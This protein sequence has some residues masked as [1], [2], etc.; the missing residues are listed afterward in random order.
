MADIIDEEI[1]LHLVDTS[2]LVA[3]A[4]KLKEAARIKKE[5]N[6]IQQQLTFSKPSPFIQAGESGLLP[7]KEARAQDMR[8]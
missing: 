6:K 7:K 5:N 4:K 1:E 8:F 2:Q 3:E